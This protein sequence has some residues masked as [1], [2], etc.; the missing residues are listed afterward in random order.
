L[1]SESTHTH[2]RKAPRSYGALLAGGRCQCAC[3]NAM[4]PTT[5]K[6]SIVFAG[7]PY[8]WESG[9]LKPFQIV[10]TVLFLKLQWG[11]LRGDDNIN[12][13]TLPNPMETCRNTVWKMPTWL[14]Y[15]AQKAPLPSAFRLARPPS[16]PRRGNPLWNGNEDN[17]SPGARGL[18]P[19]SWGPAL[20]TTS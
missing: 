10:S 20:R 12:R 4:A 6:G 3:L 16:P 5:S 14:W 13:K 9:A 19:S 11:C 18:E 1:I 7:R 8:Q 17:N 2:H 15:R